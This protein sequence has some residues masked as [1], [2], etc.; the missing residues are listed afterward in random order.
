VTLHWKHDSKEVYS[1]TS[2]QEVLDSGYGTFTFQRPFQKT[3]VYQAIF[4]IQPDKLLYVWEKSSD[5]GP[6]IQSGSWI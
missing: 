4:T 5:G 6:F 1:A 3:A 2:L